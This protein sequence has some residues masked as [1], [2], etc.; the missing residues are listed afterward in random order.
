[1]KSSRAIGSVLTRA[2]LPSTTYPKLAR[3]TTV[4]LFGWAMA[5][6][7]NLAK[8]SQIYE[9]EGLSTLRFISPFSGHTR[10]L[11]NSRDVSGVVEDLRAVLAP[12]DARLA[13]HL[14]SMNGIYTLCALTLQYPELDLLKR[15]DGIIFDSCPVLFDATSPQSFITLA[16]TL[17]K[18]LLQNASLIDKVK[19]HLWKTYFQL[20]VRVFIIE[21]AIRTMLGMRLSD[22]TPYHYLRDHPEL[23]R[24]MS[25]IYSDRDFICSP[26]TIQ[27]FHETM[28]RNGKQVDVLRLADSDHVEHFKK[29]PAEYSAVVQRF[30]S[31]LE[32]L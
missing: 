27:Q 30:L 26:R 4:V 2:L 5:R 9:K 21:Q 28:A 19:F 10:S 14:F 31:S 12:A 6:D 11:K 8:Y 32:R 25:F 20:G 16:N 24:L 29:Y 1:M 15:T 23:P 13:L 18:A 17:A 7:E 3:R 22:F